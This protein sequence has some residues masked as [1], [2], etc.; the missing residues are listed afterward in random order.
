M[1]CPPSFGNS[2]ARLELKMKKFWGSVAA[3]TI[4][5]LASGGAA[6]PPPTGGTIRVPQFENDDV[7]VWKATVTP[8]APLAMHRHEHPRVIIPLIGG[9]MKIVQQT[10][11]SE[12]NHWEAGKAYWLTT[13]QPGTMHSDVNAGTKP[14]EV[15][16]VELKNA[17]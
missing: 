10:G 4:L 6:S 16:V 1:K 15:M 3:A 5:L 12:M 7:R 9:D 14:I 8:N 13:S 17:K 2:G 11:E